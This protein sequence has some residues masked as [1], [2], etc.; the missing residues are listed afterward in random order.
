LQAAAPFL[1]MLEQWIFRG[2]I[3]DAYDEFMISEQQG[4]RRPCIYIH[5]YNY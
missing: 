3:D 4:T 5:T 2:V 1:A